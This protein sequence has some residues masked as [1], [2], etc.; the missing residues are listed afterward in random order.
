MNSYTKN[1]PAETSAGPLFPE[2]VLTHQATVWQKAIASR[3]A[4]QH[5]GWST[6]CEG[7]F[8]DLGKREVLDKETPH[9]SLG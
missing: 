9:T 5:F 7:R 2:K 4:W 3:R 6:Q 8:P 1:P